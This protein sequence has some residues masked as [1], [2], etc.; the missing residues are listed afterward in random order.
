MPHAQRVPEHSDD[1]IYRRSLLTHKTFEE[2]CARLR[3]YT[4]GELIAQKSSL[5]YNESLPYPDLQFRPAL[6]HVIEEKK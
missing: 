4:R 5:D 2:W 6:F 1:L 3:M